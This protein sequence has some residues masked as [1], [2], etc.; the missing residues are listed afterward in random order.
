MNVSFHR[1]DNRE[2]LCDRPHGRA[3][4][5]T[6]APEIKAEIAHSLASKAVA[7]IAEHH[8]PKTLRFRYGGKKWKVVPIND[9]TLWKR[10][11]RFLN[12]FSAKPVEGRFDRYRLESAHRPMKRQKNKAKRTLS[13]HGLSDALKNGMTKQEFELGVREKISGNAELKSFSLLSAKAFQKYETYFCPNDDTL[14]SDLDYRIILQNGDLKLVQKKSALFNEA[15]SKAAIEAWKKQFVDHYGEKKFKDMLSFYKL[16]MNAGL[17]AEHVYR[18]N[19]YATNVDM[20]DLKTFANSVVKDQPLTGFEKQCLDAW[21]EGEARL[22]AVNADLSQLTPVEFSRLCQSFFPTPKQRE[23]LLTGRKI[24]YPISSHY[25]IGEKGAY[26]PWIDQQE[27]TEIFPVLEKCKS[28]ESYQEL[29][30]HV[31]VK[32]HLMRVHSEHDLRLGVLIPAPPKEP[33][34]PVRY[35]QVQGC[36]TNGGILSYILESPCGDPSLP[37][38]KLY[39]STA[40]HTSALNNADTLINDLNHLNSPGYLGIRDIDFYEKQFFNKHTIPV[41]VGYQN[42]AKQALEKGNPQEARRLLLLAN[43]AL[44]VQLRSKIQKPS[45][46]ALLKAHDRPINAVFFPYNSESLKKLLK[47]RR[48]DLL[49]ELIKKYLRKNKEPGADEMKNDATRLHEYLGQALKG[50]KQTDALYNQIQALRKDLQKW[51]IDQKQP[52][53]PPKDQAILETVKNLADQKNDML[54]AWSNMIDAYAVENHEDIGSKSATDLHLSGHSLGGACA[55]VS[56]ARYMAIDGRMPLPGHQCKGFFFDEPGI[57]A[58]DNAQF[59]RYGATHQE[60]FRQSNVGFSL[61]RRHESGDV[62]PVAGGM[63]LGSTE[64][65]A[66]AEKLKQWCRYD[67]A[68]NRRKKSAKHLDVAETTAAHGTRF[69]EAVPGVDFREKHVT[70][71]EEGLFHRGSNWLLKGEDLKRYRMISKNIWKVGSPLKRMLQEHLRTSLKFPLLFLRFKVASAQAEHVLP[72]E[73][74]DQHGAFCKT[75]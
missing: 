17:T 47:S 67:A 23:E 6:V 68:V 53:L 64:T 36:I 58:E 48:G 21:P 75:V 9:N 4:C 72:E 52:E 39:R 70:P 24:N 74:L 62:V 56:M 65:E 66:D 12:I 5:L 46:A 11:L 41:W 27:L 60:L 28:W 34:G 54:D 35:Y 73:L 59:L 22:K 3:I 29:L 45:F 15:S 10:I 25:S 49:S 26:K 19:M 69:L 8:Q 71:Y 63:S 31:V 14:L 18:A 43:Q 40:R 50:L 57:N 44:E 61:F 38:I 2:Y 13:G 1:I 51:Y 20:N 16:E 33:G 42:Q 55:A 37:V 30:A 7:R 32:K